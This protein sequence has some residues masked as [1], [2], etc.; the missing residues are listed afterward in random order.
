MASED[1][2]TRLT[3]IRDHLEKE[4]EDELFERREAQLRGDGV[5]TNYSF[6]GRTV[7]WDGY[8]AGM[9]ARIKEISEILIGQEV[10]ELHVRGY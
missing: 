9:M 8:L 3:N 4:L 2:T 7:S 6:G 5:K 10:F 1:R